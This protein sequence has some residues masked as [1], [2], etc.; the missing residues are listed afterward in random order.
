MLTVGGGSVE[1]I[2]EE[3]LEFIR[4]FVASHPYCP[5]VQ[6]VQEGLGLQSTSTAHSRLMYLRGAGLVDWE[7]GKAR[8]LR[9]LGLG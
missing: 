1:S 5:T 3:T 8:T 6:E 2:Y 7:E 4:A 9:L